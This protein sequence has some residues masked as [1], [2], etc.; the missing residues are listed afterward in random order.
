MAYHLIVD[1]EDKGF[2]GDWRIPNHAQRQ[3]SLLHAV[4][5]GYTDLVWLR[6]LEIILHLT[7]RQLKHE[8]KSKMALDR[9]CTSTKATDPIK[10]PLLNKRLLK[11]TVSHMPR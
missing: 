9:V 6:T 7:K 5:A 2:F 1:G 3:R 11:Y 10:F 4:R 8:K